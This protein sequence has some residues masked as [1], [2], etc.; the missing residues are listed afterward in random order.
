MLEGPG[1]I[2]CRHRPTIHR[3]DVLPPGDRVQL[4]RPGLTV[5]LWTPRL[6]QVAFHDVGLRLDTGSL[7]GAQ[8]AAVEEA[9]KLLDTVADVE[10]GVAGRRIVSPGE[11]ED[12]TTVFYRGLMRRMWLRNASER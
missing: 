12:L 5:R 1:D 7:P 6:S 3:G 9:R 8:Q 10:V 11:E 2:P 4:E